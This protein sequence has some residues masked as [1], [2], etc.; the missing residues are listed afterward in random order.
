MDKLEKYTLEYTFKSSP[1]ILF[2]KISTPG[3][4]SEWFADN[5]NIKGDSYIFEWDGSKQEAKVIG[6]KEQ[7]YIKF[8]WID[9][10][11][12]KAY[13]EFRVDI[14]DITGDVALLITDFAYEDEQE[15]AV[16][17][18]EAQIDELHNLIG[19]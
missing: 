3:G 15:D 2:N 6:T 17:L 1:K 16:D 9:D 14:D 12:E 7:T 19:S 8:K 5:V 4:L 11:D 18:W 13:F 10:E